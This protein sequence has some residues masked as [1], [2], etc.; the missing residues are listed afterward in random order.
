[1]EI[2]LKQVKYFLEHKAFWVFA[3][4]VCLG[5]LHFCYVWTVT[6]KLPSLLDIL[7]WGSI[8]FLLWQ[9]RHKLKFRGSIISSILGLFLI[10]W[11]VIRHIFSRS[12]EN[13]DVLAYFF[14]ITILIGILLMLSGFRRL[15]NYK[16]ELFVAIFISLPITS[17]YVILTP[18]INIDAQFLSFMLHFTAQWL[19]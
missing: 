19:R 13:M 1:M 11:M 6:G 7:G 3:C 9:K 17:L 18:I 5:V 10:L 4:L 15:G 16:S 14:P 2:T 12:Q 8:A